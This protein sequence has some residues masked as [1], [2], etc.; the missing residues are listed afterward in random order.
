VHSL[1]VRPAALPGCRLPPA[2][3]R[4]PARV[5][6]LRA[7]VAVLGVVL[8]ALLC[9]TGRAW[10]SARMLAA[11]Q[12]QGPQAVAGVRALQ[13]LLAAV[14]E[15]DDEA[16]LAAINQFFNRRIVFTDDAPVW[17]VADHWASPLEALEKGRGDCEDYA[18]AKYFSL[19]AGGVPMA[20][21]RLVYV[22]AQIGGP[23]G[24][25]QAHMVLAYY[26]QPG[27]EPLILDNLITDV[28]PASRRPDLTP[29]FS[30]NGE[31]LWQGAGG[32]A[33]GDPTARLSRWREVIAKARAEG[34][35]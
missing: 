35:Q 22:R 7:F 12:R 8:L 34:F 10:D 20:K 3:A 19:I 27:A 5:A 25:A 29:V 6:R 11:A 9:D 16:R 1:T 13:T 2:R 31:G 4:F 28:R 26:A 14:L 15:L 18:I 21:L 33:A 17:G 23:D 32:P 24:I 30:F